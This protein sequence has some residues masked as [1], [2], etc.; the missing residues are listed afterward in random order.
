MSL[1]FAAVSPGALHWTPRA[2]LSGLAAWTLLRSGFSLDTLALAGGC[3]LVFMAAGVAAAASSQE[4][5][6][7]SVARAWLAAAV[8]S[9]VIA[10]LQYFGLAERLAPLVSLS[11]PG[12]AFANLRQRNQF[13]SLTVI[14]M[15]ALLWL[16]PGGRA[17]ASSKAVIALLAIGNAATT[18]RTGLV[19]ILM[20]V[21]IMVSWNGMRR[22][23]A[24]LGLTALLAYVAAATMLPELLEML[25]GVRGTR[26]WER[27][28]ASDPCSS[29]GVLWLNVL[30]LIAQRPWTGWGWGELDYAHFSHLYAGARFCDILDNAH[31]LPLH[32]AVELGLPA[33]VL[34]LGVILW[35]VMRAK[36]WNEQRPS[37]Q[38]GWAVFAVIGL[39]SLLEY[40]LWYGPFQIALG[41]CIGMLWPAKRQGPGLF[42]NTAT[43]G[44]LVCTVIATCGYVAWEYHRISQIYLA[45]ELRLPAMREDP[46]SQ[47]RDSWLFRSQIRFAELTITPLT[48]ANA[49][50]VFDTARGSL[51]FSPE[52]RVIEKLIESQ[53]VLGRDE[54]LLFDLARFRAAFPDAYRRW[55]E[56]HCCARK[57]AGQ[58]VP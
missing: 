57:S 4:A 58:V 37:R 28:V 56:A 8:F 32:L 51:H 13:A 15:A 23:R 6:I 40:P 53:N 31:N 16:V 22:D 38:M 26:L 10:L 39:H 27:V 17:R 41:L 1:A 50:W 47:T 25:T 33:A 21:L 18:S 29:R 5:L 46:L 9:T 3:L 54:E 45:P 35:A 11:P 2:A 12:E 34:L 55:S 30:D 44:L 20:L 42:A 48:S 49:A 36:P 14:G 7:R 43:R 19:Q 24:L 52:P